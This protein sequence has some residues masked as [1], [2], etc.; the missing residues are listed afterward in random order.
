[1]FL[2]KLYKKKNN[3]ININNTSDKI[4]NNPNAN[5]IFHKSNT[6]LIN[7]ENSSVNINNTSNNNTSKNSFNL[8]KH[9]KSVHL[10]DVYNNNNNNNNNHAASLINNNSNNSNG[11]IL[12]DS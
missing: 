9:V 8:T 5:N 12:N 4:K 2:R 1:M 7:K 6:N 3:I 10:S 11:G